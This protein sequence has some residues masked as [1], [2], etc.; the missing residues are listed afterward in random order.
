MKNGTFRIA[1]GILL[2]FCAMTAIAETT[3]TGSTQKTFDDDPL[4]IKEYLNGIICTPEEVD[5]WL[6]RRSFSFGFYDPQMGFFLDNRSER[7][8]LDE[9]ICFYNYAPGGVRK[10]FMYADQPCRINTYGDSFVQC[11]QVNDGETWQEVLAAHLCEPIRN[12]GTGN[13]IHWAWLRMQREEARTPAPY[14][15]F[16]VY[17]DDH[18]RNV[19]SW[20]RIAY[21]HRGSKSFHPTMPY[22]EVNLKTGEC[23]E[24]PNVCQTR[25]S[26]D[27]LCDPDWVFNTF[28]DDFYLQ[29]AVARHN[30]RSG[31]PERSYEPIR[32]L[33]ATHGIDAK[34]D[35]PQ[36]LSQAAESL[37]L[38][39]GLF[40]TMRTI[41]KVEAYA[42][43]QNKKVLF[44]L[45]Y[46]S[47]AVMS[48]YIQTGERFDQEM[49][50]FMDRK[51]LT[52]VDLL[53]V[54]AE[55][56]E[57]FN[58]PFEEY[59]SRYY[60]GHYGP[61]GNLFYAFSIKDKIVEMMDPKPVSYQSP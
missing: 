53:K 46:G 31:T 21:G 4:G 59:H 19:I 2:S 7:H 11:E 26:I 49:V 18:H 57:K 10:M 25:D 12:Y 5:D 17:E 16:N 9:S 55:Y 30:L 50:D 29:I 34:I 56:F 20:Q 60:V 28:K 8:G 27:N 24:H 39:V 52:Y 6:T 44:V 33:A 36:S 51:G 32:R 22:V 14:I 61:L 15:I 54:H 23:T 41:E 48:K 37:M 13:S 43:E 35:N 1:I 3:E 47:K 42:R 45:S 58:V 38:K 40:A